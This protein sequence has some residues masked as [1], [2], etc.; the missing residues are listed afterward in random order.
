MN[1]EIEP[2]YATSYTSLSRE[3]EVKEIL[4]YD[5]WDPEEY[6]FNLSQDKKS[7]N[8]EIERVWKNLQ[9]YINSEKTT[10]NDEPLE[11]TVE[12]A[13]IGFRGNE[14]QPY[15]YFLMFSEARFRA[16]ENTYEVK[17]ER[18]ELEYDALSIWSFPAGSKVIEAESDLR[19]VISGNYLIFTGRKGDV[20]SGHE[21][22]CF[23]LPKGKGLS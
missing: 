3:G 6:Y 7:L 12:Y 5:Y 1:E 18:E 19:Y 4:I 22:I 10:V 15:I 16:G 17:Y 13:N 14:K 8:K 20:L 2:I 11:T 9:E 21:K 23:L